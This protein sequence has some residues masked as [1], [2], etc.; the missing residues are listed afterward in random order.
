MIG[1]GTPDYTHLKGEKNA[2]I[3]SI[4]I[5]LE[6]SNLQPFTEEQYQ[7]LERLTLDIMHSY[8]L[9][10]KQRI[11]EDNLHISRIEK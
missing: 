2:M 7:S 4:G 1:P 5:E 9:I 6:G 3:F 11:V 10:T 8:P